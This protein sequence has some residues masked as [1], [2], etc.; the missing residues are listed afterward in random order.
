[1]SLLKLYSYGKQQMLQSLQHH[2]KKKVTP[3]L[4]WSTKKEKDYWNIM[5]SHFLHFS[6]VT[7]SLPL[8]QIT[9]ISNEVEEKEDEHSF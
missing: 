6:I 9:L 3:K 4:L 1:M 7:L 8:S 2:K 5:R